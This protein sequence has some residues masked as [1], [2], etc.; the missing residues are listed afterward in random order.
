MTQAQPAARDYAGLRTTCQS[1]SGD[2]A[3]RLA[4]FVDAAWDAL[5][6][7]NVSWLGFYLPDPDKADQMLLGP[8]RDKPAC[9][10]IGLHGA[11]GRSFIQAVTLVVP[12]VSALGEGYIACD[13]RDVAEL[14]VPLF[15]DA[16]RCWGV[17]DLDS[18]SRGAFTARDAD[19]LHACLVAA[20]LT[21]DKPPPVVVVAN[22]AD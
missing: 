4:G 12:D 19:A 13:P 3:G 5:E 10:P 1:L 16:K 2:R 20:G 7:Q 14:V 22:H 21:T 17:L 18:Y 11:C 6:T 8:R 15:D 9:S